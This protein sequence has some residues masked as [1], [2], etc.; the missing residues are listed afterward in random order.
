M[1]TDICMPG[2]NGL[3]LSEKASSIAPEMPVI[4]MPGDLSAS[5]VRQAEEAGIAMV[6]AKPF[7]PYKLLQTV[8]NVMGIAP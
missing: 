1:I 4:L 7:N 2:L 6:L 3:E 5:A 8:N